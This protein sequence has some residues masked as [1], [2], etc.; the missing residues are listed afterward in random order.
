MNV[1]FGRRAVGLCWFFVNVVFDR[2]AIL[3][4]YTPR[5]LQSRTCVV[6]CA[7]AGHS[8]IS[9]VL[10]PRPWPSSS[11]LSRSSLCF[12]NKTENCH[13]SYSDYGVYGVVRHP[14]GYR[15]YFTSQFSLGAAEFHRHRLG[16][17][18][19]LPQQPPG[20]AASWHL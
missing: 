20:L 1:V 12:T 3:V 4:G 17:W 10:C 6:S 11:S 18:T 16:S 2:R 13:V 7:D 14:D 15:L 5:G 8:I 9:Q 19:C